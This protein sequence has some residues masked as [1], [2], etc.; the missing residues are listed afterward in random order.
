[1]DDEKN[2]T[3]DLNIRKKCEK[4]INIYIRD[5]K[6]NGVY[7]ALELDDE[8]AEDIANCFISNSSD[9]RDYVIELLKD[10]Y[11]NNVEQSD[12]LNE[13]RKGC[14]PPKKI[15]STV[16]SEPEETE[17]FESVSE[18]V[19]MVFD[20]IDKNAKLTNKVKKALINNKR[21]LHENVKVAG[22]Y[23]KDMSIL[24]LESIKNA[25]LCDK[26]R[27]TETLSNSLNE[28]AA[29]NQIK[30]E[31]NLK[32]MILNYVEEELTY[33]NTRY[34]CIRKLNEDGRI[35]DDELADLFGPA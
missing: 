4:A 3:D 6:A 29:Y 34:D 35:S 2:Y 31:I 11:A 33:R 10:I 21:C 7:L 27:L 9:D 8:T 16:I 24:E 17:G 1:L 12:N 15:I 25:I 13:K 23:F 28:S 20:D 32:N 14:C 22:K 19:K 18:S 30:R 5:L 26:K